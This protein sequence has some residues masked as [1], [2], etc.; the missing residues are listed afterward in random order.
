VPDDF[1]ADIVRRQ[2]STGFPDLA[3]AEAAVTLPV[4]DRLINELIA[5]RIPPEAHVRE[6][7]IR[8]EDANQVEV[9]LR[10]S[11]G[12][13]NLP[14]S[15]TL[16]ID[17][18]P[19]L[20]QRPVLGLRLLRLPGLLGIAGSAL[21]YFDFLP[22]GISLDG[23]WVRVNI[24]TLLARYGYAELLDHLTWIQVTT[25]PGAIIFSARAVID[26]PKPP[27]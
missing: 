22:P 26:Y 5:A 27:R 16:V 15:L 8:C 13:L 19:V 12:P 14:V 18:Q 23:Q 6:V 25:R 1:L 24:K 7:R 20:P 4:G 17:E 2:R 9:G 3:G 10:I 21:R 11:K